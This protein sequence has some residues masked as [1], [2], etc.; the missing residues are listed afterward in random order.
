MINIINMSISARTGHNGS[1]VSGDVTFS[2]GKS[3]GWL[4]LPEGGI[5]FTG[6]R[7]GYGARFNLFCFSSPKRETVLA[8]ALSVS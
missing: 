6:S 4:L 8:A 3:Y 7:R 2:D 1:P 5:R